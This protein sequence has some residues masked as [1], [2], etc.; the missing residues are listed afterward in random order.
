VLRS[1]QEEAI[2]SSQLEGAATTHKVA[3]HMLREQR[4][5]RNKG[6]RMIL[7]NY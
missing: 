6:E 5:P 4:E 7:N 3:K 1:L 2:T